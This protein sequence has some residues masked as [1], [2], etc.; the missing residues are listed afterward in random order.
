MVT[1]D[2]NMILKKKQMLSSLLRTVEHGI[3]NFLPE[4]I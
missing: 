2:L 4:G 3:D 1:F